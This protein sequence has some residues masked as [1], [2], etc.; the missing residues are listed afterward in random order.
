MIK[1]LLLEFFNSEMKN[2]IILLGIA[3]VLAIPSESIGISMITGKLYNSI[4]IGK[5]SNVKYYMIA[6]AIIFA[7][8]KILTI[9][10]AICELQIMPNFIEFKRKRLFSNILLS[11]QKNFENL[12]IGDITSKF[13]KIPNDFTDLLYF[14]TQGTNSYI[15]GCVFIILYALYINY[16]LGLILLICSILIFY[17]TYR[18]RKNLS[19]NRFIYEKEGHKANNLFFEKVHSLFQI[20]IL[21]TV[22]KELDNIN[23]SEESLMNYEQYSTKYM[24][25]VSGK[26]V[27]ITIITFICIFLLIIYHSKT[28]SAEKTI[29]YL[30]LISYYF[31]YIILLSS[32]LVELFTK[33][34]TYYKLMQE[35]RDIFKKQVFGDK[36]IDI[37]TIQFKSVSFKYPKSEKYILKDFNL[38]LKNGDKR[39]IFGKSGSGKSTIFKLVM[40]FFSSADGSILVNG[41][42]IN[43]VDIS[44]YRNQFAYI[45]QDTKLFDISV[46]DNIRY[47]LDV[48]DDEIY[49]L[50][51]KYDINRVYEKLDKGLNTNAGVDGNNLSGGQKQLVLILRGLLKKPK[52]YLFDEPTSALDSVTRN[53]I[54]N[55][56]KDIDGTVLIISHDNDIKELFPV[57]YLINNKLSN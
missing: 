45:S 43:K 31:K 41:I 52:I 20:Y 55:I 47:S 2:Y 49:R 9:L 32:D 36:K 56:L 46:I 14:F 25:I 21:N 54:F 16:R 37:Q 22:D 38:I 44:Y 33:C 24:A 19:Q 53:I 3:N 48:T 35:F 57:L 1:E 7:I 29:L 6:Y 51:I 42:D 40:G 12:K 8:S 10:E 17:N 11:Y 39:V 28:I 15:I 13:V 5:M 27:I 30:T 23:K 26:N 18:S 34:D 4:Q 50:I